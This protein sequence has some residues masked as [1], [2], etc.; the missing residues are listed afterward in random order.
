MLIR[1]FAVHVFVAVAACSFV[2]AAAPA[3]SEDA[4]TAELLNEIRALRRENAENQERLRVLEQ[5]LEEQERTERSV[6]PKETPAAPVA[7]EEVRSAIDRYFGEDRFVLTGYGF[8]RHN[9]ND[10]ENENSFSAGFN[11]IFLYRLNDRVLFEGELELELED[12][13]TEVDLEYAQIDLV[14]HDYVTLV[15][16]KYLLPFGQFIERLHPAWINKLVTAPL[17]FDH[18]D[19]VLP[20]TD[21]GVQLRGGVPLGY[22]DGARVAYT[23][24]ASNGPRYQ[25][26]EVGAAF[27]NNHEDLNRGKAVGARVELFPLALDWNAGW[28]QVGASTYDGE[29]DSQGNRW[30]TSWGL[31][32]FYRYRDLE[33][34]GEYVS[35]RRELAGPGRDR[36]DGWYAQGSYRL[37][38][39]APAPLNKLE[40]ILRYAERDQTEPPEEDGEVLPLHGAVA[41]ANEAGEEHAELVAHPRQISVGLAYWITPSLVAKLE[42]DRDIPDQ[43]ENNHQ[44]WTELAFGF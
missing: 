14:L 35:T 4:D 32:T 39:V 2:V 27:A 8:A 6:T 44:I 34:R 41:Q 30:F 43:A 36:R 40:L 1:R 38:S 18:H 15:A 12:G 25:S 28:L 16:G 26:G 19:G 3:W 9:W 10:N 21:V 24:Y 20:F 23:V 7:Q 31:D 13:E 33:L 37:A 29:W 17:P 11:P 5:R 22:G 42:Y